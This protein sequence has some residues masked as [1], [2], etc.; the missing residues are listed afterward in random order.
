[1]CKISY[2]LDRSYREEVYELMRQQD[3]VYEE[4]RQK[5]LAKA[6]MLVENIIQ[7]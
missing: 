4:V 7:K 3:D 5:Y 1:M 2:K 6:F